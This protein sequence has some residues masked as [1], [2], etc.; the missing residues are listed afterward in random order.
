MLMFVFLLRCFCVGCIDICNCYVF[1]LDWSLDHYIV[2]FLFSCNIFYFK[3]YF[4]WY[5]DCYSSFLLLPFAWTIFFHPLTTFSLYVSLGLKWLSCRQYTG[6]L[7]SHK[8]ERFWVSSNEGDEP[9]T[10]YR[11]WSKSKTKPYICCLQETPWRPQDTYRLKVR[12][13]KNMFHA[14]GMQKK[15]GVHI[16]QNRP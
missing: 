7:L 15:A 16:R 5:E 11:E 13:W 2:F 1:L 12:G 3:V 10:Y 14:N 4:V 6:I 8:K 9:R